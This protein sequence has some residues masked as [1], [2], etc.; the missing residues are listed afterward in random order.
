MG[1]NA[2]I[3]LNQTNQ[4]Q[5]KTFQN[6]FVR[7]VR[8]IGKQQ[9]SKPVILQFTEKPTWKDLIKPVFFTLGF[10]TTVI[11]GAFIL[12]YENL[13]AKEEKTVN[14]FLEYFRNLPK[15]GVSPKV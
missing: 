4:K 9:L 1:N 10:S 14:K 13:R 5:M 7:N 8:Q 6:I 3:L 12:K 15:D 11:S 2:K